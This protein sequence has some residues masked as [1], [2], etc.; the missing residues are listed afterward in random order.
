MDDDTDFRTSA[1]LLGR[2]RSSPQDQGAWTE[3]QKRYGDMI[4]GWCRRWGLQPT[5]ADDLTQ[6]VMMALSRQMP[7][8]DYDSTLRF[9]GWLKTIARRAW[10][11]FLEKKRK[12]V[13]GSGDTAI[14]QLI[15]SQEIQDDF[16]K[17]IEDEWMRELMT[18]AMKRV[19]KRVQPHTWEVFRLV[20]HDGLSGADVAARLDMKVGAVWV[21]K[22]K[23]Q[24]MIHNEI[25]RLESVWE[26]DA[27]TR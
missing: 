11:D 6:D 14:M 22:S 19:Q 27:D 21:A 1:T 15:D 16:A 13:M 20:T 23:V 17:Q 2:L 18:E 5:D 4:L 26:S 3:F 24:K 10:C 25:R 9:R 12:L 7:S 8:F